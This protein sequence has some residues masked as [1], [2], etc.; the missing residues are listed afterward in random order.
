M[1]YKGKLLISKP[2]LGDVFFSKTVIFIVEYSGESG[3]IGFV[4]NQKADKRI[5]E[6]IPQLRSSSEVCVGGPVNTDHLFVIHSRGDIVRKAVHIENN[7][8][9]GGD[10]EDIKN[11]VNNGL[12]KNS[13]IRYFLGYSGWAENQLEGELSNHDWIVFKDNELDIL[14]WDENLWKK[15]LVK[16]DYSNIIWVNSPFNPEMN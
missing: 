5:G 2:I 10:F 7:L 3:T 4:L 16:A 14:E 12:I 15:E 9:W 11:G 1:N 13:E 8:Y 6:I